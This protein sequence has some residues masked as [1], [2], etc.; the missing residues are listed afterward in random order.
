MIEDF[1]GAGAGEN[2]AARQHTLGS[3]VAE[4]TELTLDGNLDGC[5]SGAF[6]YK[7]R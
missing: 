6:H 2:G 7:A 5:G 4:G 3:F 1:G